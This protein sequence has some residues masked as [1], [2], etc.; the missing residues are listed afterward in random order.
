M[1]SYK[2]ELD[3]FTLSEQQ[4]AQLKQSVQAQEQRCL[5]PSFFSFQRVAMLIVLLFVI[6]IS[7]GLLFNKEQGS[8]ASL[9]LSSGVDMELYSCLKGNQPKAY[10]SYGSGGMEDSSSIIEKDFGELLTSREEASK[11]LPV[12][13]KRYHKL[14]FGESQAVFSQEELFM[15]L[16]TAKEKLGIKQE[17]Q[18]SV[19]FSVYEVESDQ[20]KLS[21]DESGTITMRMKHVLDPSIVEQ[22]DV[23]MQTVK[24]NYPIMENLLPF[25][26]PKVELTTASTFAQLRF[27]AVITEKD[28]PYPYVEVGYDTEGKKGSLVVKIPYEKNIKQRKMMPII[29]KE[30][31]E[32]LLLHGEYFYTK[33]VKDVD[34][35]DIL[36]CHIQY[37]DE[38]SYPDFV[39]YRLPVYRFYVK[40]NEEIVALDVVAVSLED[41]KELDNL[42]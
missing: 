8:L 23:F 32:T 35:E 24:E 10:Q 18:K 4:K 2:E 14:L 36:S 20:Y 33:H 1:K 3:R 41:L 39:P 34:K 30:Q 17:L 22:A 25:Q 37:L 11:S 6:S 29:T 27:S 26:N 19:A 16:Q 15:V 21:I 40:D 42:S 28:T 7:Y 31:A 9:S 38:E 13:E 5:K 12:Y